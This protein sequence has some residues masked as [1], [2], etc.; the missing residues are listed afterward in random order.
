MQTLTRRRLLA[1]GALAAG[2]QLV[3]AWGQSAWPTRPVTIVVGYPPGGGAD[4]MARLVASKMGPSLGQS[5]V[6][7]NKGGT[8]GQIGAGYVAR[9]EPDGYTAL[10]DAASFAINLGLYDKL[11]YSRASFETV[12][13]IAK[14][15]L[16]L[17]VHPSFPATSV[18]ELIDI[19][20]AKPD[21]LFYASSGNGSLMHIATSLFMEKTGI[22][23]THVPYK[24]GAPAL[25]DVLA[26]QVPLYFSNASMAVPHIQAGK[27]RALAVTS[28]Q[29]SSAMPDVPTMAEA[30]VPEVE[31]Y[32]WNGMY[33]PAGTPADR[34]SRLSSALK[35]ALKD[36]DIRA[37]IVSLTGEPFD[38]SHE[39]SV[40]FV[41]DEITRMARLIKENN[42]SVN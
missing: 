12:G 34:I 30:G 35:E 5:I 6:I 38:G 23:M 16:V 33:V 17:L 37:R 19:A 39:E 20:K 25:N 36:A 15:P 42:I 31:I 28:A 3:P 7:D 14:L 29:R 11:P 9:S 32:E 26:G 13:V 21:E 10:V 24:G 4:I 40:R 2:S 8:A 27:V 22:R 41:N 1:L 18:A